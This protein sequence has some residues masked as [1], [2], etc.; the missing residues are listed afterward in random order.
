MSQ[1]RYRS[2]DVGLDRAAPAGQ[3][4]R[5]RQ[6]PELVHGVTVNHPYLATVL[7]KAGW[8]SGKPGTAKGDPLEE[9]ESISK[10]CG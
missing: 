5:F 4:S 3:V 8:Y 1:A 2:G 7:R 9:E 6:T 10:V